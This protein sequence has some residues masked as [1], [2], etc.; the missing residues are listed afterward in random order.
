MTYRPLTH[1][2]HK[3]N[4]LLKRDR[5]VIGRKIRRGQIIK[6]GPPTREAAIIWI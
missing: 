4:R 1:S 6:N 3:P 5:R 2:K